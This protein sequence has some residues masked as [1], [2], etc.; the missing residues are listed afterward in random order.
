MARR[1]TSIPSTSLREQ[2]GLGNGSELGQRKK[3]LVRLSRKADDLIY[4]V[5]VTYATGSVLTCR[6]DTVVAHGD[7]LRRITKLGVEKVNLV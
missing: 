7:I 3:S 2:S 6:T 4:V 5:S 1:A